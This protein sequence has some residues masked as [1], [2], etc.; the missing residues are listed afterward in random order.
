MQ[1]KRH[2]TPIGPLWNSIQ[3]W[4]FPMLED[5]I[6]ELDEKQR[7]FVAVCELCAPQDHMGAYRWI[8]NGCPPHDRLALCKAFI[9]KAVWDYATTRDLIDAIRH[10]PA[11]RR[12]CGWETLGEVPSEATFS[13]AFAAFAG[14]G[15]PQQIHE[16]L[17]KTRYGDKLAGQVVRLHLQLDGRQ[18]VRADEG[19]FVAEFHSFGRTTSPVR[20]AFSQ[21][22]MRRP[23][24][25][26][27][28]L[29]LPGMLAGRRGA[30]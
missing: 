2:R 11:L 21:S 6:G 25:S 22:R 14:N 19:T 24:V 5:E 26:A 15:C 3:S 8:S 10:C 20:S 1:E 7:L 4:L 12:L 13:R 17:I 9:A 28:S 29:T 23:P 18:T 16:A 27:E 30:V